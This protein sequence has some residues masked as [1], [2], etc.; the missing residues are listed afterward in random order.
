MNNRKYKSF[1]G[2]KSGLE[3]VDSIDKLFDIWKEAHRLE[4]EESCKKTLPIDPKGQY[5]LKDH[6]ERFYRDGNLV[7]ESQGDENIDCRCCTEGNA[8]IIFVG[9]ESNV[10]EDVEK[11]NPEYFWFQEVIT[12][13]EKGAKYKNCFSIVRK[14]IAAQNEMSENVLEWNECAY[15]NINKRGGYSATNIEQLEHYAKK[16]KDFILKQIY[17]LSKNVKGEVY[18]VICGRSGE[19]EK[20]LID[21]LFDKGEF[22]IYQCEAMIEKYKFIN[23]THPSRYSE[24][25][26]REECKI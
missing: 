21:S 24:V 10:Q 16:Y 17:L 11:Q 22:E 5:G 15:M 26:I 8:K 25:K 3:D 14:E 9:K 4:D 6:K 23:I 2:C 20:R 12:G 18:I 7:V 13:K 19:W 1:E